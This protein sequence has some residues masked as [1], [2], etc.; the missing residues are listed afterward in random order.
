MDMRT[1]KMGRTVLEKITFIFFLAGMVWALLLTG[2][3]E[4]GKKPDAAG[5]ALDTETGDTQTQAVE[6][7]DVASVNPEEVARGL[8]REENPDFEKEAVRGISV[9]VEGELRYQLNYTPRNDRDSF[10]YWD[11]PSPYGS[12]VIV[13]TEAMYE[14]YGVM[15]DLDL[16]GEE[17]DNTKRP[18]DFD[19]YITV[20]YYAGGE[21][22]EQPPKPNRTL[23]LFVGESLEGKYHCVLKGREDAV[24]LLDEQSV[25]SIL[26]Q[27]PY[28]L[29]LKIPYVVNVATVKQV[30]IAYKGETMI[31]TREGDVCRIDGEEVE[32]EA[33]QERYSALMQ[34]MLDGEI[35]G[36]GASDSG[37]GQSDVKD[38]E[39]L[40]HIRYIRNMEGA[41]DYDVA[42]YQ[43]EDGRYTVSVNGAEYFYLKGED[44]ENLEE[45]LEKDYFRRH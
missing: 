16:T 36:S 31:M 35:M 32:I 5:E 22:G 37:D 33:Y 42:I 29:I 28:D 34:P 15:A 7:K 25:N 27:N 11:M 9:T 38:R 18:E 44:V 12:T 17:G 41:L 20:N 8:E 14:L 23:T 43:N 3:G 21:A 45:F 2:C 24:L 40:I 39:P 13:D 19:T 26:N 10:L 1:E 4:S 30:E 6:G